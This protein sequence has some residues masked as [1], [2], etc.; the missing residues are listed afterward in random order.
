M[1]N[2]EQ[3][4][5]EQYEAAIAHLVDRLRSADAVIMA[6]VHLAGGEARVSDA[7]AAAAAVGRRM[8][9]TQQDDGSWLFQLVPDPGVMVQ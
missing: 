7:D 5:P 1:G 6:L 2:I 4:T 9:A 8:N 3:S